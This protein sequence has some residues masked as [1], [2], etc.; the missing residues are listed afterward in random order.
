M[1]DIFEID[2][3]MDLPEG[4]W[5]LISRDGDEWQFMKTVDFGYE[6]TSFRR[7]GEP[8]KGAREYAIDEGMVVN[9]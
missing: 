6:P 7:H 3:R 4:R 1:N 8:Y 2:P 9:K 5:F